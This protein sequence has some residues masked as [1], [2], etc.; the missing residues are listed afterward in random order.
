VALLLDRGA[1]INAKCEDNFG[2][3][4][5]HAAVWNNDR[6]VVALLL[7]R[8]ADTNAI[9][10][11]NLDPLGVA[12]ENGMTVIADIIRRAIEERAHAFAMGHH[13]RLGVASRVR[14]LDPG[15]VKMIIGYM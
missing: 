12:M 10:D 6:N 9:G 4:P 13:D 3:T 14:F 15:V 2:S 1:D 8:G 5:I 7:D 11:Q